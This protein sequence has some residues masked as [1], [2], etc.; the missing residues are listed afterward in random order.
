MEIIAIITCSGHI[1]LFYLLQAKRLCCPKI[2]YVKALTSRVTIFGG[3]ATKKVIKVKK[4]P[5]GGFRSH[6]IS[7]LIKREF[8]FFLRPQQREGRVGTQ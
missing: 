1:W 3:R 7:V 2:H 5:K 8:A 6:G 4:G